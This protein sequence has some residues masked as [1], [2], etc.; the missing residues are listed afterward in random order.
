MT[1]SNYPD[2]SPEAAAEMAD[3]DLALDKLDKLAKAR[4]R[5]ERIPLS[6]IVGSLEAERDYLV[7][8]RKERA[9]KIKDMQV[10]DREEAT[11]LRTVK[12]LLTAAKPRDRKA[13]A[14]KA[15]K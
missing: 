7:A 3:H 6:D 1:T 9:A 8:S 12:R 10:A 11:R 14:K 15:A 2:D 4:G 5:V 13:P